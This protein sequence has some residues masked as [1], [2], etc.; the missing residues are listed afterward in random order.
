MYGGVWF[1][2]LCEIPFGPHSQ[3]CDKGERNKNMLRMGIGAKGTCQS[4]A[5]KTENENGNIMIKAA[6]CCPAAFLIG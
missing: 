1:G 5:E 6:G 3:R 4:E 2:R